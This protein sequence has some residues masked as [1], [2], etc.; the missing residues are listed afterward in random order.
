MTAVDAE[1][2]LTPGAQRLLDAASELFYA[3]GIHAVG[4]ERIAETAGVTK[5]TLYDRFGSKERLVLA[6]LRRREAGWRDTLASHLA[7]TPEPGIPRILA[8]FDAAMAW[9]SRSAAKG[10]SAVNARAETRPD[11]DDDPV[12]PEVLG[13]K[14]WLLDRFT[15]LCVEAG[16]PVPNQQAARLMILF[17]G[18]LVSIAMRTFGE[19]LRAAR[20]AAADL[21][22]L[23]AAAS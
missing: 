6:Y 20:D 22:G 10:C 15:S 12:L 18:A 16:L 1:V 5:K 17:D 4:V 3:E 2:F 13:E 8:V 23:A 7:E 14:A 19:P 11:G 21:L 9:H